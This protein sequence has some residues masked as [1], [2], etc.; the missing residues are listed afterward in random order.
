MAPVMQEVGLDDQSALTAEMQERID[1]LNQEISQLTDQLC[2]LR[3]TLNTA[4]AQILS[5]E[6]EDTILFEES[7]K[8]ITS[9]TVVSAD[10]VISRI[11][12][13]IDDANYVFRTKLFAV[14][15]EINFVI[16]KVDH[17]FAK[18]ISFGICTFPPHELNIHSLPCHAVKLR[19]MTSD[20]NWV[21]AGDIVPEAKFGRAI[22]LKRTSDGVFMK[23]MTGTQ[24]LLE[25]NTSVKA[26]PFFLFD[27]SVKTISLVDF[28]IHTQREGL[29]CLVCLS[30][31]A[32][33]RAK[34]CGHHLYCDDCFESA[35]VFS[36]ETCCPIPHCRTEINDWRQV[37]ID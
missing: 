22:C 3:L 31:L 2:D 26:Y 17:L 4:E 6:D 25:L 14:G 13:S 23:R 32:S 21:I 29:Q 19:N 27:G 18:S 16:L 8:W 28:K 12:S 30:S 10:K 37:R 11:V 34:P 15:S 7:K 33:N 20:K 9:E 24:K 36:N 1:T 5:L 35:I